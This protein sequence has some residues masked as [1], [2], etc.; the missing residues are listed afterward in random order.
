P[1]ADTGTL[2]PVDPHRPVVYRK[3]GTIVFA[4][5]SHNGYKPA[6]DS[7]VAKYRGEMS[8]ADRLIIDLRGNEGGGSFM[9]NDLEPFVSLEQ[10]LPNPFP[11]DRPLMLSSPDQIAYAR[12]AFGSDT[13][14]FVRGLV[15]RL[16]ARPGG[17]V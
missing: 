10:G 13:T 1:S 14:A 16:R 2:D 17:L 15:H 8:S 9:T 4:I 11:T 5:P 3:N 6:L 7:L 12:R